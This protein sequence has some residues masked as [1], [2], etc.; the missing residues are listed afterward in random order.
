MHL[1]VFF[2]D[3]ESSQWKMD[4]KTLNKRR[5]LFWEVFHIDTFMSLTLGRPPS[6]R[7]SYV[8]CQFPIDDEETLD[9]DGNHLPGREFLLSFRFWAPC[10]SRHP[11]DKRY[12]YDFTK[13][14][15]PPLFDCAPQLIF[16]LDCCQSRRTCAQCKTAFLSDHP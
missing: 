9:N 3:R 14:V 4:A 16:W 12:R 15:T 13:K 6:I 7:L 1:N 2:T 8:D 10:R 11:T 5:K